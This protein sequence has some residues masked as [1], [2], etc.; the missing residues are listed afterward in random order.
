M[1][2]PIA[3]LSGVRLAYQE[4]SAETLA[5]NDL[6]FSVQEGEFVSIVGPSG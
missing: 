3:E 6:S 2:E 4:Q 5:V 1:K